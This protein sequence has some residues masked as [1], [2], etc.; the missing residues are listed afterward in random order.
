MLIVDITDDDTSPSSR[1]RVQP[2]ITP[3][4]GVQKPEPT[5]TNKPLPNRT[6]EPRIVL[7]PEPHTTSDLVREPAKMY[8]MVVEAVEREGVKKS[9][10]LCTTTE[11]ELLLDSG[12]WTEGFNED[13][14]FFSHHLQKSLSVLFWPRRLFVNCQSAL[15]CLSVLSRPRRSF[16]CLLRSRCW[17]SQSGVCGQR[18]P[19]QKALV[20]TTSHLPPPVI[21]ASS[22]APLLL[23]VSPSAHPQPTICAVVSPRVCQSPSASWL[24]DPLIL[25]ST[26]PA[27]PCPSG[28][29]RL[30]LPSGSTL[31][32]C[33]SGSTVTFWIPASASVAGVI[34]L[35]LALRILCVT[36]AYWLSV[37]ASGSTCSASA[38]QP[39]GV[40]NPS[41]TMAPPC[42]GSPSWVRAGSCLAPP[43]P[44]PSCLLPGSSL[45]LIHLGSLC[46]HPGS[47]LH[48]HHP[49]I[50]WLCSSQSSGHLLNL[51]Q[52]VCT[53]LC[54]PSTVS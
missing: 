2:T 24:E 30:F 34:C 43:A 48:H 4:C 40:V 31:V 39:P 47:S 12:H 50:C 53:S 5:A 35:V 20:L 37:F 3:L 23:P 11:G 27:M 46:F 8:A 16:P 19:S 28:S 33:R 44:S 6:T 42:H 9:P 15:N 13:C 26:P 10:N 54:H 18:T 17:E 22:A 25:D 32:L 52:P 29:V 41:S 21:P 1:P 51:L 49:G 7:E 14:P 45:R 38:G 36:L